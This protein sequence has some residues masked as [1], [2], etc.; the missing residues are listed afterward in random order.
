MIGVRGWQYVC[1]RNKGDPGVRAPN[2]IDTGGQRAIPPGPCK[3][4]HPRML[5]TPNVN[6][7]TVTKED[8]QQVGAT[9]VNEKIRNGIKITAQESREQTDQWNQYNDEKKRHGQDYD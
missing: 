4:R 8:R 2:K 9:T 6:D 1:R 3:T 7:T 5:K